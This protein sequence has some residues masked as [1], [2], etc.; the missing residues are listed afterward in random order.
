M[1]RQWQTQ[2]FMPDPMSTPIG[3]GPRAAAG[4]NT[5]PFLP[6]HDL[7]QWL[8][9]AKK[10]GEVKEVGG[11]SL[12]AGH[13]HGRRNVGACRRRAVLRVRR[14][15][16]HAQ[17]QPPPGQFLRRQAQEHD[18]RIF[19]RA[20]QARAERELP[21]QSR[22]HAQAH[23]AEIRR[24]RP[25]DAERHDKATPSTSPNSRRRNG[26][27]RTAAAISAPAATTSCAIPTTAGSIAAPI[28]S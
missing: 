25:G 8:E 15:A 24:V 11:L 7:R 27:R 4:S 22:R 3:G 16:G 20:V 19:H 14:R 13:R 28:A 1:E 9:E 17:R 12:P 18:A 26:I 10:L 5:A 21:R 2:N 6:Y 23:P